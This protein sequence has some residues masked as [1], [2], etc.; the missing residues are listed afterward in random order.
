MTKRCLHLLELWVGTQELDGH[1]GGGA[2]EGGGAEGFDR[3]LGGALTGGEEVYR[4]EGSAPLTT[5]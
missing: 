3:E 2:E 5:G 4:D 1:G